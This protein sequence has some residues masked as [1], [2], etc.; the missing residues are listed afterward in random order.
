MRPG[1]L[2]LLAA[3]PAHAQEDMPSVDAALLDACRTEACIGQAARQCV[4][5]AGAMAQG[6][7]AGAETAYWRARAEGALNVLRAQAPQV[8]ARAARLGWP[9]PVPTLDAIETGFAAYRDAACAWR[10]AQ[11]DGIHAGFEQAD[12]D[13]RLTARHALWLEERTR[14]D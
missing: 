13:L 9:D 5:A 11:W 8:A 10:M 2:L 7:C 14:S 3:W 4:D 12:C 6:V 1:V